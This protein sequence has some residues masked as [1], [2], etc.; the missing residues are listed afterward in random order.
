MRFVSWLTDCRRL[1]SESW[2]LRCHR[3]CLCRKNISRKSSVCRTRRSCCGWRRMHW[4]LCCAD[5]GATPLRGRNFAEAGDLSGQ[6][7]RFLL[8]IITKGEFCKYLV[9]GKSLLKDVKWLLCISRI[10]IFLLT[11]ATSFRWRCGRE[12]PTSR[13]DKMCPWGIRSLAESLAG[14][15]LYLRQLTL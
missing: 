11:F 12:T 6:F 14:S 5:F 2:L 7:V 8:N 13:A 3:Y 9:Y 10:L 15:F 1:K 4:W